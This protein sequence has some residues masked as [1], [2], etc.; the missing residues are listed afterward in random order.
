MTGGL[1]VKVHREM[2][3]ANAFVA[4]ENQY[5]ATNAFQNQQECSSTGREKH[6]GSTINEVC[7]K[8]D[9]SIQCSI[10]YICEC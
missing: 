9:A 6:K 1:E 4:Q 2:Q 3:P 7:E 10:T 5:N 8:T